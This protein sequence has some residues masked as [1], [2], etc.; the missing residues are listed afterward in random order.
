MPP[1][2]RF[3]EALNAQIGREY[4]AAHQ[5]TA[6]SAWY[7]A[8]TFPRLAKF[9]QHQADEEREHAAKMTA[10][11]TATGQTVRLGDIAAPRNDFPDHVEPIRLALQQEQSVTIQIAQL[12]YIAKETRDQ[13]SE[14][15]LQ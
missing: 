2:E 8:Q 3:V 9:F 13:A 7:D 15:F 1:S 6:I 11:L 12:V 10:Y 4:A 14:I 5:Y